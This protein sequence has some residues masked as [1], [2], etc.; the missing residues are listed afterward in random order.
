LCSNVFVGEH[1]EDKRPF[2]DWW[3]NPKYFDEEII[4]K[5]KCDMEFPQKIASKFDGH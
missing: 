3:I 5:I 2:E 1:Y 4:Q